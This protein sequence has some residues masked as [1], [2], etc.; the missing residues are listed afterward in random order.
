VKLRHA[1]VTLAILLAPRVASACPVCFGQ[2]SSPMVEAAKM[3]VLFMLGV[4]VVML[5]AF[6]TFFIH[7]RRRARMFADDSRQPE[8]GRYELDATTR[9]GTA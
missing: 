4:T 8:A 3:G 5:G 7:L 9:E 2:S 1:L 6:A